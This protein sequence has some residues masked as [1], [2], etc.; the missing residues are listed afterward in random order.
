MK[1]PKISPTHPHSAFSQ[2]IYFLDAFPQIRRTQNWM[3]LEKRV[4]EK[5][6]LTFAL[7]SCH[8]PLLRHDIL[9]QKHDACAL[10]G[11][12]KSSHRPQFVAG[13]EEE[14][15]MEGK[16]ME[17]VCRGLLSL[18]PYPKLSWISSGS[19]SKVVASWVQF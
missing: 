4:R 12:G 15:S 2:I 16:V 13:E 17:C 19:R 3:K 11:S 8:S 14:T 18:P 6:D 5:S 7:Y 10:R 1:S 9:L